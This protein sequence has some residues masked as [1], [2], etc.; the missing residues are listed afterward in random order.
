MIYRILL[1]F[2][3]LLLTTNGIMFSIINISYLQVEYSFNEYLFLLFKRFETWLIPIGIA[4]M[5]MA[6]FAKFKIFQKTII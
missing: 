3:G 1:F 5:I 4:M 2:A 6:C